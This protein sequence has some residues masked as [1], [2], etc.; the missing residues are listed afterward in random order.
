MRGVTRLQLNLSSLDTKT[1]LSLGRSPQSIGYWSIPPTL[2]AWKPA[3]PT[4]NK[5]ASILSSSFSERRYVPGAMTK[6]YLESHMVSWRNR[7]CL[8]GVF[9][10]GDNCA[11][12][13]RLHINDPSFS[14]GDSLPGPS[15]D[16]CF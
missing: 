7:H 10:P 3:K 11:L 9:Q 5:R 14:P 4:V 8:L 1:W 2:E 12:S 15:D 6:R 16:A 13:A